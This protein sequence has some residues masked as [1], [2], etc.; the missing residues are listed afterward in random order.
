[1]DAPAKATSGSDLEPISSNCRINSRPSKGRRTAARITCQA[2]R[3]SSPNHSRKPLNG[4]QRE[5]NVARTRDGVGGRSWPIKRCGI[6]ALWLT[7]LPRS[8]VIRAALH[9]SSRPT[10]VNFSPS[11]FRCAIEN[12]FGNQ[13]ERDEYSWNHKYHLDAPS[14][15]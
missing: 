7:I 10:H 1:M 9:R 6:L 11:K 8:S 15:C 2:K 5:V 3:P 12:G 13:P 4:L 14:V